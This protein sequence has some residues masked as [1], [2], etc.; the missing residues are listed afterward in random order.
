MEKPGDVA[1]RPTRTKAWFDRQFDEC[2]SGPASA[3]ANSDPSFG[4]VIANN[5]A[6]STSDDC[7]QLVTCALRPLGCR[8]VFEFHDL[9]S[10]EALDLVAAL[11]LALR[12]FSRPSLVLYYVGHGF[13]VDGGEV[14]LV[15]RDGVALCLYDLLARL[16]RATQAT[17]FVDACRT[18]ERETANIRLAGSRS[19]LSSLPQQICTIFAC[20]PGGLVPDDNRFATA[21][22]DALRVPGLSLHR[23]YERILSAPCQSRRRPT[24][25][26][27]TLVQTGPSDYILNPAKDDPTIHL[28]SQQE[29][30]PARVQVATAT[31]SGCKGSAQLLAVPEL[32]AECEDQSFEIAVLQPDEAVALVG[33][34]LPAGQAQLG[35]IFRLYPENVTFSPSVQLILPLPDVAAN[36]PLEALRVWRKDV[37]TGNVDFLDKLERH[38]SGV[39]V[40]LDHFCV[41]GASVDPD[42]QFCVR[43]QPLISLVPPQGSRTL[44]ALALAVIPRGC[45]EEST[46]LNDYFSHYHKL[47]PSI[48]NM[49][50]GAEYEFTRQSN[51]CILR[52]ILMWKFRFRQ[53][54]TALKS[55]FR[56]TPQI[57]S[58]V[59]P[60]LRIFLSQ[61]HS[62]MAPIAYGLTFCRQVLACNG[63]W[64][65]EALWRQDFPSSS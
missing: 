25:W 62:D 19:F 6:T 64:H 49:K 63:R 9:T 35:H 54:A 58:W 11:F 29:K 30:A 21:L 48:I 57:H 23:I 13:Q 10:T 61:L 5:T 14:A 40:H 53:P 22:A 26:Q 33:S 51:H 31:A 32:V 39:L 52:D 37:V 38:N 60:S 44:Y 15:F 59:W 34:L 8:M 4:L 46:L 27:P 55:T 45:S 7:A 28:S 1:P 36:W 16:P 2:F 3:C 18:K 65:T 43:L 56:C 12:R 47:P 42:F 24:F 17:C 41:V 20:G 50:Y